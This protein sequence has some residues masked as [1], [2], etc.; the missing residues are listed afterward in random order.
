MKRSELPQHGML[1]G[2]KVV[3][4]AISIAGPFAG[5]LLAEMGADVIQVENPFNPDYSHGGLQPGWM[6]ETMRRNMRNITLDI[7]KPKGRE[8]FMKLIAESDIFIEASKGGQWAGW[9]ITDEVLWEVNPK[10]V[11]A[12]ISGFG[13]TGLEEY[14]SRASYDPIAQ[15]FSGIAYANGNDDLPF[16]PVADNV[17]DYY[18]AFYTA[19]SCLSAYISALRTGKGES[20]DIAQYECGLRTLSQYM[21]QDIMENNP[22]RRSLWVAADVAAAFGNYKCKEGSV[23]VMVVGPSVCKKACE[24]FGLPYNAGEY[25]YARGTEKGTE[26]EGKLLEF[27]AKHSAD[28]VEELLNRE[29]IPCSQVITYRDMLTNKQYIARDSLTTIPSERWEDP[30]NP[31]QPLPVRVPNVFPVAK[32]NP[33]KIWRSGV[34]FGFDTEDILS[35]LGYNEEEIKSFFEERISVSRNDSCPQYKHL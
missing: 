18:T 35:D 27:C 22:E 1:K 5:Q 11:I 28:E 16:F 30:E 21:L 8:A 2:V 20:L 31:G 32:N 10:L 12:H 15:A 17:L 9:G 13:Q 23:F 3:F 19:T 7:T 26:I 4:N 29:K 24:F 14:T 34:D 25:M 33:L 6:G